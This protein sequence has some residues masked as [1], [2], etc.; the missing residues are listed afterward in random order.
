MSYL[1][2]MKRL[3][4]T[5]FLEHRQANSMGNASASVSDGHKECRRSE[6]VEF[7]SRPNL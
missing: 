2:L 4:D 6:L 5:G 1:L 7:S 3:E